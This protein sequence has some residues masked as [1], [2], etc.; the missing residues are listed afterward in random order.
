VLVEEGTPDELGEDRH[1][2]TAERLVSE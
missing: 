2:S 1:H